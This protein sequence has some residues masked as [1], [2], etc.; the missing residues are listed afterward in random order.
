MSKKPKE[1][2]FR[3]EAEDQLNAIKARNGREVPISNRYVRGPRVS[4]RKKK[5]IQASFD[6]SITNSGPF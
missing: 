3:Q 6:A 4:E 1:I 5:R 2:D